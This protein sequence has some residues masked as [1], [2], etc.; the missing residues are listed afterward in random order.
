MK[1][2][3]YTKTHRITG[4]KYFGK[5]TKDPYKYIGSGLYWR[6]HLKE[7]GNYVDTKIIAEFDSETDA[8]RLVAFA[9]D[10]SE[11]HA[12]VSSNEW[13]NLIPENG[14]DGKPVGGP[15]HT[16]TIEERALLSR[17]SKERWA[18]P[19]YREKL[20]TAQVNS[21][22]DERKKEWSM[23]KHS[24]AH[25]K[26][27][28]EAMKKAHAE[29]PEVF[30]NVGNIERTPAHNEAIRRGLT[31]KPK[32]P[33]HREALSKSMK[34]RPPTKIPIGAKYIENGTYLVGSVKIVRKYK[35]KWAISTTEGDKYFTTLQKAVQYLLNET[36]Q[37]SKE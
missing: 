24:D 27:Q 25:R 36:T 9:L 29:H 17:T 32:S 30:F 33:E 34:N 11:K 8:D 3:L 6:K 5:T 14:L 26:A 2:Y 1:V 15:G 7:H 31:G 12:I 35:G 19:Q 20:R 21:W 23:R 22:T 28:S 13:A 18:D 4:L 10:F 37:E 16:F